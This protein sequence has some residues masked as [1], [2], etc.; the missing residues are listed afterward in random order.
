MTRFKI[1]DIGYLSY[2]RIENIMKIVNN[3]KQLLY[4]EKVPESFFNKS[5]NK[6]YEE[7]DKCKNEKA[8]NEVSQESSETR[9]KYD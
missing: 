6:F 8:H 3:K 4:K 9:K 7:K 2:D 5:V 1:V